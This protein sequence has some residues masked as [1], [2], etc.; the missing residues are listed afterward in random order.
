[1][2]QWLAAGLLIVLWGTAAA[3]DDVFAH[4][5]TPAQLLELVGPSARALAAQPVLAGTFAQRRF[6]RDLPAP[7]RSDGDFVF[8]K[9]LGIVW[10]T[11]HP[12]DAAF[13]LTREGL[14]QRTEGMQTTRVGAGSQPAL[15]VSIELFFALFALD[16]ERLSSDF[17]VFAAKVPEG[18][19]IGLRPKPGVLA[20]V[21]SSLVIHGA[22]R[23]ERIDLFEANGDRS[24]IDLATLERLPGLTDEQR[25]RFT[26]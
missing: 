11:A 20:A 22:E 9:E 10:H 21:F 23:M 14:T 13:V 12:F 6:L 18:W 24:E 16:L 25:R 3:A 5:A 26:D 19:Q 2:R 1:V 15:R 8:S 17:E 4:P 7:L